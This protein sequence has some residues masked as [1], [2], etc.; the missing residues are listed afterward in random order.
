MLFS[1]LYSYLEEK[2]DFQ[3]EHKCKKHNFNNYKQ[4]KYSRA[5]TNKGITKT[6]MIVIYCI[7]IENTDVKK[8]DIFSIIS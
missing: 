7:F 2:A 6:K 3:T 8:G 1:V 4:R 5:F